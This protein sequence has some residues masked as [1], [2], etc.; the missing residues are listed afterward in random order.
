MIMRHRGFTLIELLIALAI[1]GLLIMLAGPQLAQFLASSQVR[2]AA[3]AITNGVQK[4][5]T[6]AIGGNAQTRFVVD[7]NVSTGGWEI[8]TTD[9]QDNSEP[10][11]NPAT[12]CVAPAGAASLNPVQL[13]CKQDGAP[14]VRFA[15]TPGD[16]TQIT[17]DG[18]GRMQCNAD[19]SAN[20]Q[21]ID[22]TNPKN[23][24]ARAMRVCITNASPTACPASAPIAASQIK[25]CDP[26]A[27]AGEPQACPA[28]C[29]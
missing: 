7:T 8:L 20:L 9:P 6:T 17:F 19:T 29:G 16:A 14:D 18:L 5:Q 26:A 24:S 28:S 13:Y 11:P 12:P 27:A 25:L 21:W 4:A 3:E 1:F 23:T 22:V 15:P 10:A 2:N